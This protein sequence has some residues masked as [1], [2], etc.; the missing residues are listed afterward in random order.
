MDRKPKG[1]KDA[2][3]SE[4]VQLMYV[5]LIGANKKTEDILKGFLEE[6][7]IPSHSFLFLEY[8][9]HKPLS[10]KASKEEQKNA[11]EISP[12]IN[13]LA[14][15]SL[16]MITS[17][18]AKDGQE[19]LLEKSKPP[20]NID[21]LE[22]NL[23][24]KMDKTMHTQYVYD[25]W[26]EIEKLKKEVE[27]E[28][29][30]ESKIKILESEVKSGNCKWKECKDR[31]ELI[32]FVE[33][34]E[35]YWFA[36]AKQYNTDV[37]D[38]KN[39]E[40]ADPISKR[41]FNM[42]YG[43]LWP[44]IQY[45]EKEKGTFFFIPI[46]SNMFF[47]GV[48]FIGIPHLDYSNDETKLLKLVS[49]LFRH[50]KKHYVP[51]L[52]LIHE[53]FCE[54]LL[55]KEIKKYSCQKVLTDKEKLDLLGKIYHLSLYDP[56]T[57]DDLTEKNGE[58]I[59]YSGFICLN[60]HDLKVEICFK[61]QFYGWEEASD[62][63]VEKYLHKLWQD[64]K[65]IGD[66]EYIAKK[67]LFFKDRLYTAPEM[68][69]LLQ[70]FL[71]P[72]KSKLKKDREYLPSVLV[73]AP[74][75]SGKGFM[76]NLF[77]LFSDCYNRGEK[78]TLN[79]AALKPNTFAPVAMMGG[80]ITWEKSI[81]QEG[82]HQKDGL[83]RDLI[84][85]GILQ[86]IRVQTHYAFQG[87]FSSL[88]ED[89]FIPLLHR[90]LLYIDYAIWNAISNSRDKIANQLKKKRK[91]LIEINKK[92]DEWLEE[93][94]GKEQFE[95]KINKLCLKETQELEELTDIELEVIIEIKNKLDVL[96]KEI[97]LEKLK[98]IGEKL[99]ERKT[100][101][102]EK[103]KVLENDSK[104]KED[105]N[106]KLNVID[107][108]IELKRGIEEKLS[109]PGN[110]TLTKEEIEKKL[111]ELNAIKT[112][113]ME[114]LGEHIK[115]KLRE[116]QTLH[117]RLKKEEL[118]KG[119]N[120]FLTKLSPEEKLI[121]KELFGRFPTLLLDELNSLDI[122]SQ[123]VLLRFIENAEIS[124]IGGYEDKMWVN[125]EIE[126]EYQEFLT[127]FLIVGLM[128]EDPEE[129]TREKGIRFLKQK[130]SYISGLLGDLLYEH[131]IRVRRLRPDL[132]QRMMRNGEFK[133]PELA[134]HRADIPVIF[135]MEIESAKEEFFPNCVVRITMDALEYLMQPELEWP[136]NV[137]LLQTLKQKVVEIVYE[138][139][140][141]KKERDKIKRK[142][143]GEYI[144]MDLII[145]RVKHIE[146]AMKEIGM[147]KE[148]I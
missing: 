34:D 22:A 5:G 117:E 88:E 138:D 103:R 106:K 25:F 3:I 115:D 107:A 102:E 95:E 29:E 2:D 82:K 52:A 10:K 133:I 70:N 109:E 146:K 86:Q 27:N 93:L 125:G 21:I 111:V 31:L 87:F 1:K 41:S 43:L 47:Y 131:I 142:I 63:V 136:E 48:I 61:C 68:L 118:K 39:K 19:D 89:G 75:G 65:I 105:I 147:I 83:P 28:N 79:M 23:L 69:E 60:P 35:K 116:L 64:R 78:Y 38:M 62:N 46:A 54:K 85:I 126:K 9:M 108:V 96:Q 123:G 119:I 139:Y 97:E 49:D 72:S 132:R 143:E 66:A 20:K 74:P 90:Y 127:D 145:I 33:R 84:L 57:G 122:D 110:I 8:L 120:K 140:E 56:E 59:E 24:I 58:K 15:K 144:E 44:Q 37:K 12:F 42:L 40:G 11:W 71:K 112:T 18:D 67:S 50:A 135:S 76:V 32:S 13:R 55:S 53:H 7:D 6:H 51:A 45:L 16:V 26:Y 14:R 113:I 80:E 4:L 92:L 114:N 30:Y 36:L 128:N 148:G 121:V 141:A 104:L 130:D 101:I 124:T 81:Y 134:R 77:K 99:A 100:K 98:Y 91:Y 129:I 73:E 137:R 17:K 94:V